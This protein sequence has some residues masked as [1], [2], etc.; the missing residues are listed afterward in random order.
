M[1]KDFSEL[2]PDFQTRAPV[3]DGRSGVVISM[4]LVWR[5][6]VASIFRDSSGRAQKNLE[7][8]AAMHGAQPRKPPWYLAT[9]RRQRRPSRRWASRADLQAIVL[10]G[11]MQRCRQ[12]GEPLAIKGK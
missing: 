6:L 3:A 2:A 8:T 9:A 5:L 12:R 4:T 1:N 10:N 7:L 11:Q